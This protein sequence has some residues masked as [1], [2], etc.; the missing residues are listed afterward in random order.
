[1]MRPP[2]GG[3]GGIRSREAVEQQ[4]TTGAATVRDPGSTVQAIHIDRF[5]KAVN[6]LLSP[7]DRQSHAWRQEVVNALRSLMDADRAVMMLWQ[8]GAP[9]C[10]GDAMPRDVI[11]EYLEH[12]AAL[13][14]GMARRD[15]LRLTLWNRSLLWDRRA[16]LRSA[17]YHEFALPH[18]LHDSIGLSLDVE[19]TA[20][21]VRVVL[22]Y[23]GAPLP[24]PGAETMLRRLGLIL[25][26]IRT[27]LGIHLRYE[28]WLGTVPTMLD[29]I[30]ERLIL[31]NLAGRELHRN[32][33]MRRTLDQ[34]PDRERILET[35]EAVAHA[36]AAHARGPISEPAGGAT[37]TPASSRQEVQTAIGRYR[38]RGCVVGPDTVDSESAVLVSVDRLTIEPP[39]PEVLRDRFGLTVREVQ[40]ACLLV[41]RLT[42]EE[43]AATLGISSHTARH[44]TESVLLKVGVKSR[45]ALQR[46]LT[47]GW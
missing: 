31:Y 33:T 23:G 14:H 24:E 25:P 12:F 7:L 10:Y 22:L 2:V 26:M 16:L 44:H 4:V 40:V 45:R 42:N 13:D 5:E 9:L 1:M 20:A 6:L 29:R 34:D 8:G 15:A 47:G 32:V 38:L 27:G 21:H 46:A 3:G 17:Y 39:S 43:I 36:V 41:Q 11:T 37:A 19:G 28:R 18:D 30:G 35:A